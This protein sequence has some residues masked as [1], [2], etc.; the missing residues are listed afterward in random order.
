MCDQLTRFRSNVIG[1]T[2]D[3]EKAFLLVGINP[4]D[5][6]MLRFLWYE[7]PFVS[8]PE[9][10]IYCFSRL[11]CG[12]RPSPSILGATIEH[13]LRLFRQSEPEI[14]ELLKDE[15]FLLRR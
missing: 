3:N 1:I 7:D 14:A 15:R 2:G 4:Q 12:L 10:I 13:H 11:V 9:P 8:D 6:D 5:R